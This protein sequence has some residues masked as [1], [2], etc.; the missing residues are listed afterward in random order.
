MSGFEVDVEGLRKAAAAAIS[1]GE[2]AGR[3]ELG[4]TPRDVPAALPGSESAAKAEPL[5]HAW[6]ERLA[7]WST[8]VNRLGGNLSAAADRYEADEGAAEQDFTLLGWWP[9][10]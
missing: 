5:A 1:A 3:V 6:T 2:Q 8:D 7:C 4:S 9:G 10:G